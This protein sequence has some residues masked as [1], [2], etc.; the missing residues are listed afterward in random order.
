MSVNQQI[1]EQARRQGD[2][3]ADIKACLDRIERKLDQ[4]DLKSAG[5]D[6]RLDL[7]GREVGDPGSGLRRAIAAAMRQAL[8]EHDARI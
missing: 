6:Q 3:L 4:V 7:L 5:L 8:H 2:D 1:L